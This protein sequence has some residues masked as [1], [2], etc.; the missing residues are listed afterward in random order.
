MERT[1]SSGSLASE[2]GADAA[3]ELG[4]SA[5]MAALSGGWFLLRQGVLLCGCPRLLG[6]RLISHACSLWGGEEA[7]LRSTPNVLPPSE[8][9][10]SLLSLHQAPH[11][12]PP[13]LPRRPAGG[14][15]LHAGRPS[16]HRGRGARAH[17]HPAAW[18]ARVHRNDCRPHLGCGRGGA[19]VWREPAAGQQ[20]AHPN[21]RARCVLRVESAC[22]QHGIHHQ[23][24]WLPW[25][26]TPRPLRPAADKGRAYAICPPSLVATEVTQLRSA[27]P[28][29]KL[30]ELANH[31]NG[32]P[33]CLRFCFS[34]VSP[35]RP[36][37]G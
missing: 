22:C 14:L 15:L 5:S 19:W 27:H 11:P 36:E 35:P 33:L 20:A 25:R 18:R 23:C 30:G 17:P 6:S 31:W 4:R 28:D 9:L 34:L 37:A 29:F 2:G 8:P 1:L 26:H 16:R 21:R 12:R 3:S 24:S 32:F 10:I 13:P 7:A